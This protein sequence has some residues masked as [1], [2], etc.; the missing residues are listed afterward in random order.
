MLQIA[1]GNSARN[2]SGISRRSALKAGWLGLLGLSSADLSRLRAEGK[3]SRNKKSVILIWLDGG[4]SQLETFDPKPEA[5]SE[6]R[7]PWDAIETNVSGVRFSEML[8]LFSKHADKMCVLRTVQ[9]GNVDHFAAAHWMLT[10]RFGSDVANK[11]PKFP[12]VGSCVS[13]VKGANAKGLPAY[14]GLPAAETVNLYPGYQGATY[15]GSAHDPFQLNMSQKYLGAALDIKI[16]PPPIMESLGGKFSRVGGRLDLLRNLDGIHREVDKSGVMESMDK[17]NQEAV[18]MVLGDKTRQAF[19]I[20]KEDPSLRDRYGRGPWGHYALMARRLVEAGVSFVTVDMPHWDTHAD[21][22]KNLEVRLP[23]FDRAVSG[24][25][26]DL[27]DR[28][29]LDD[30][31]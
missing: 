8:P 31:L 3:A 15:L 26:G 5:P 30:V 12:S 11:T 1:N 23:Y 19:D 29:L 28:R 20:E 10:G 6:F 13:R 2:C 4:P 18:D 14:V 16:H 27:S 21:L 7:G 9:H 17:Y 24:L 22:K 25:L